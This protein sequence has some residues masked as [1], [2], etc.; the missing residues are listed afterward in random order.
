[1]PEL[2]QKTDQNAQQGAIDPTTNLSR[3]RVWL[4]SGSLDSTV[5]PPVM[6]ALATYY[7]HYV[8]AGNIAFSTTVAAEHAMPTDSFGNACGFRGDPFINDCDLDAAGELLAWI[9]GSL[10]ARRAG[11]LSGDFIEFDQGEFLETPTAHGM[12]QTGWIYAPASCRANARCRVHIVF[13][14]CKQYPGFP[15]AQGPQGKFGDTYVKNTGY[16]RWADTN[17]IV[18][19]FPQAN[20]MNAGTRLPRVNPFGCWDWWG[21]D[22][23]SYARKTGRQ[24]AAVRKMLDR[25]AGQD[26]G[27]VPPPPGFCGPAANSEHVAANRATYRLL[28]LYF[29]RG[30][31]DFLGVGGSTRTTLEATSPGSYRRVASCP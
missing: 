18:V 5:Q 27:P 20:A 12:W 21:Y 14:G 31:N 6:R 29:A 26:S 13:H 7:Q 2:I 1:M 24:M 28:W 16:V 15:Y 3:S 23:G 4:F 17:G 10:N 22:D 8:P 30:S 19:L 9:Y 25:L 11:A